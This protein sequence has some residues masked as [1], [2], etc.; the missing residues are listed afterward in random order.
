[1]RMVQETEKMNVPIWLTIA[2]FDMSEAY[3]KYVKSAIRVMMVNKRRGCYN[4]DYLF[5]LAILIC[6]Y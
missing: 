2:I 6:F 5:L 3:V 4:L 1:M